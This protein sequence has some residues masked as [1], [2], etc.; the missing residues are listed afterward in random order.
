MATSSSCWA[1]LW[2]PII[3]MDKEDFPIVTYMWTPQNGGVCTTQVIINRYVFVVIIIV[4]SSFFIGSSKLKQKKFVSEI[5]HFFLLSIDNQT[6]YA[7]S[8]RYKILWGGPTMTTFLVV[9]SP[10]CASLL[11]KETDRFCNLA[12]IHSRKSHVKEFRVRAV[13]EKTE[14]IESPSQSSSAEEVTKKYGLEAGLWKV[15]AHFFLSSIFGLTRIMWLLKSSNFINQ[16]ENSHFW[17]ASCLCII[18]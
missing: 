10:S 14:E 11:G 4:Y 9:P 5:F 13:R 7:L 15:H 2:K 16:R 17:V 6:T 8:I 3:T 18:C 1:Y 12:S